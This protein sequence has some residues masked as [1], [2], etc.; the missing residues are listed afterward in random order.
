[1][2]KQGMSKA[3]HTESLQQM[4]DMSTVCEHAC[5]VDDDAGLQEDVSSR[6]ELLP[7]KL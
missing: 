5:I 4:K 6:P 3:N 7:D 2:Q 1:M